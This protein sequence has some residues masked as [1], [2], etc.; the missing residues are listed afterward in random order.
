[1]LSARFHKTYLPI[2]RYLVL[3]MVVA[4]LPAGLGTY[5]SVQQ[6]GD[7][8]RQ[9]EAQTMKRAHEGL[10]REVEH[11]A[12]ELT[13]VAEYL[14]GWDETV[15]LFRDATYYNYW[16]ETRVKDVARYRN[17]I[18]AVDLY[19]PNAKPLTH[20]VTL[21]A[22]AF[23]G[24][25]E[26]SA[27]WRRGSNVYLVHFHPV[28]ATASKSSAP[29]GYVGVRMNLDKA[30]RNFNAL[31]HASIRQIEWNL[32]EAEITPVAEGVRAARLQVE[33]LPEIAAFSLLV[34]HGFLQYLGYTVV[35]LAVL[36]LLLT[37]SIERPLV[38]LAG[39]L[40]DIRA[41]GI[42]TIPERMHGVVHIR[43]L[44]NVRLALNEYKDRLLSAAATLEEKNK[45]LL[46][47]TYHDPL[48]GR[49]NRR[50]FEAR[51][52]HAIE[53]AVVEGKQHALCYLDVDQFKV[54]NDTCGHIAGDELLKQVA[55]L[56][57]REIRDSDMLA[58][59]GGD[60]F[61][62]L[63][64]GCD[65]D[66]AAEHAEAM[67][68]KVRKHRFVWQD[69]PFDISI[70][71]GLV[72]VTADSAGLG[73]VLKNA[74]AACYAAKDAGRN[75]VQIYREHDKELAQR[76]GEMQWVSRI[77]QAL[78]Q[79]RFEL[80]GQRIR[81]TSRRTSAPHYEV[82]MR[83]RDPDGQLVSPM[84]FI[85][86]AERYNL[87]QSIDQ[88]VV[89]HALMLLAAQKT[90]SEVSLAINLSGQS[91]ST[92]EVLTV[93]QHAI[94]E[95]GVSPT[96]LCFEITETAA[97]TNLAAATHFMRRLRELGCRF[98]LDDFGSGLSSFGY[99]SNLEVDYIK[100]DGHF[101][102]N[103]LADP[104]SRSIV[105][106][107]NRIGHVL[108]I[109]TIAEFVE[110]AEVAAA[111]EMLG[112]DYVQGFGIHRPEPLAGLLAVRPAPVSAYAAS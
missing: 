77:Q 64:E 102:K 6:A 93:I 14:A 105:E 7:I 96:S 22:T 100:I 106:S 80:H 54:V 79:D 84:A 21:S 31:A 15:T 101:I 41:G 39:Y 47:L 89:R 83:L 78:A 32:P 82:L 94:E 92:P 13:D 68:L 61:G 16:K 20:D 86:A 8:Q 3:F 26:R 76:Y 74:D 97:I 75:R 98:A 10:L 110:S 40:R 19:A 25:I 28:R 58:R 30:L 109:S 91:L 53:T 62:V 70:S 87:M 2:S 81:P 95:T 49:Y 24:A 4:T 50:A 36:A 88:W 103:I 17:L 52:Q 69:K 63:L 5:L 12:V 60:E 35:L 112:I 37:F 107:I 59:L 9:A 43:E 85:P 38:R 11:L 99:L 46:H 71:I 65:L 42:D 34:R 18:D 66:K 90:G 55:V 104:L 45:E 108:G 51:L 67:R 27:L 111:L 56:L 48:T 1:V 73:D 33:P 72:P 57:E 29:L 44:E 23:A